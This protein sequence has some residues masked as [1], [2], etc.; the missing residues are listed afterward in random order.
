MKNKPLYIYTI[1]LLFILIGCNSST[2]FAQFSRNPKQEES[3]PLKLTDVS[4]DE[5]FQLTEV[6]EKWQNE[7]AVV[8]CEEKYYTFNRKRT[9]D[10]FRFVYLPR[11]IIETIQYRKRIKLQS[12]AAVDAFSDFFYSDLPD[13]SSE[14]AVRKR[15]ASSPIPGS[16]SLQTYTFDALFNIIKSDGEVVTINGLDAFEV[17][18]KISVSQLHERKR[19]SQKLALPKLEIGDIVDY[20]YTQTYTSSN[21]GYHAFLYNQIPISSQYPKVKQILNISMDTRD[22]INFKSL[23]GAPDLQRKT[24]SEAQ[25][26]DKKQ[27]GLLQFGMVDEMREKALQEKWSLPQHS[28]PMVK[29]QVVATLMPK[30]KTKANAFLGEAGILK[31]NVTSQ[32]IEEMIPSQMKHTRMPDVDEKVLDYIKTHHPNEKDKRKLVSLAYYG[33]RHIIMGKKDIYFGNT[34]VMNIEDYWV[35]ED[36]NEIFFIKTL[37]NVFERLEIDASVQAA[38]IRRVG[39]QDKLLVP[40]ELKLFLKVK[41]GDDHLILTKFRR[42]TNLEDIPYDLEGMKIVYENPEREESALQLPISTFQDNQAQTQINIALNEDMDQLQII[43][44]TSLTGQAKMNKSMYAVINTDFLEKEEENYGNVFKIENLSK[45]VSNWRSKEKPRRLIQMKSIAAKELQ[46]KIA[47]YK[48]FKLLQD[49]RYHTA[50]EL[51]YQEEFIIEDLLQE[52]SSDTYTVEIGKFIGVQEEITDM[53]TQRQHDIYLSYAQSFDRKITLNI[54]ESHTIEN[55]ESLNI[56]VDNE[57]GSFKSTAK[58]E[59]NQLQ[60]ETHKAYKNNFEPKENWSKM[61]EVLEAAD[62]FSQ[63]KVILKKK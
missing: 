37:L 20:A 60:I 59:G 63:Q 41:T 44:T 58:M 31:Q 27:K 14:V 3:K 6:P 17:A 7:S 12:Q 11:N 2:A 54:P 43:Q 21:L 55:I 1:S 50:P 36:L 56:E 24:L 26:K 48:K 47:K 13:L 15:I 29:F 57:T 32:D 25:K 62:Q 45:K 30:L 10:F 9:K 52:E 34:E 28:Q 22:Y 5:G 38:R 49:G 42:D 19:K 35:E 53:R 4:E 18:E 39:T 16:R 40:E 51:K 8:L 46:T 61:L 33:Y 23:N